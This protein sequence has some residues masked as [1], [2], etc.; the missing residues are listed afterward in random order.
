MTEVKSIG[1][2]EL[3]TFE[4]ENKTWGSFG[5]FRHPVVQSALNMDSDG[6]YAEFFT[7]PS[8]TDNRIGACLGTRSLSSQMAIKK[9]VIRME[10]P[11]TRVLPFRTSMD[12]QR[13]MGRRIC[14]E[15]FQSHGVYIALE[16][17]VSTLQNRRKPN[18]FCGRGI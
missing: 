11:T 16:R 5:S 2:P 13:P 3:S 15:F 7:V 12:M 18:Q 9:L 1:V 14:P 4:V 10:A 8:L 6:R 17:A